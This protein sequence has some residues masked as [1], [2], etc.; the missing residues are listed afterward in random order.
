ML[1]VAGST[2][3]APLKAILEQVASLPQPRKAHLFFGARNAHGLYDLDSLEKMAAQ[4]PWLTL[5]PAVSADSRFPGET[6]SLPDVVA[7]HGDWS[8]HDVYVAGPTGLV[9]ETVSRLA[10]AGMAGDQI[11]IEDF[12]WSEP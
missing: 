1:L 4:Y 7:R 9:R 2:G 10:T 5:T 3:L 6:G 11:H 12:G 8:G